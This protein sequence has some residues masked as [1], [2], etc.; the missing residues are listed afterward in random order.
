[1]VCELCN[2]LATGFADG[3]VS[4]T[5]RCDAHKAFRLPPGTWLWQ[6]VSEPLPVVRLSKEDIVFDVDVAEMPEEG[7]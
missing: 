3:G 7:A 4:V 5:W 6:E 1:M 2:R